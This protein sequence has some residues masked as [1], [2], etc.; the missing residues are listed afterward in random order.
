MLI[1]VVMQIQLTV[2]FTEEELR[3][4]SADKDGGGARRVNLL[5]IPLF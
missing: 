4:L 3:I 5:S 2:H 1:L